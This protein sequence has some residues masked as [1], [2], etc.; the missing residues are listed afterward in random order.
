MAHYEELS[1]EISTLISSGNATGR[2]FDEGQVLRRNPN[3]HDGATAW[4]TA[5]IRDIDKILNCPYYNRYTDKTQVFSL[6]KND[7]ISHRSLHV[8]LVS[9]IARTIGKAL[10]LNLD[11]IEAAAL[12]HDI[13]HTPF[14]HTG[15]RFLDELYAEHTSRRF[16][17]NVHSVRVLDKIFPLNL[18]LQTLSAI[19]AH[20][21]ELELS[22]YAPAPLDDFAQ[23][24]RE[25]EQ[26]YLD[27]EYVKRLIPSTLEGC[28][29]RISDIIAYLGKDRQDAQKNKL[30]G[31]DAFGNFGIGT[32]NAEMV[33]NLMVN[34]IE[35]SYGKPYV[36]MD[37]EHFLALQKAK[38][39]NYE[40][41]Y[42][43][44]TVKE[45]DETL[46]LMMKE[47]YEKLLYDYKNGITSSP[48]YDHHVDYLNKEYYKS[49]RYIPYEETEANQVVVDYIA[50]MTDDYFIE[51]HRELFPE[52]TIR[53]NYKGYFE[54]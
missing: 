41:I 51:L 9:R 24:D 7:D 16:A 12:G 2:A 50:S 5:F 43:H 32:S 6:Y 21:G 10:G 8:Q 20:N 47:L 34:I 22:Q 33:N 44:A 15:E 11:L 28:V 14:G 27:G 3:T 1:Q 36:K 26:C 25:V 46:R 17:H 30:L 31:A 53:I 52:S 13:G 29:V 39:E 45:A 48:I 42:K 18:T 4:R 54:H 49:R 37:G 40:A 35:H 23:F 19:V 38:E